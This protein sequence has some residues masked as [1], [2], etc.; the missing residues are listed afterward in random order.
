[1]RNNESE[2][3]G[4]MSFYKG[5]YQGKQYS[6]MYLQME[7]AEI[8]NDVYDI[9]I[10]AG[11]GGKDQGEIKGKYTEADITLK[12]CKSIKRKVRCNGI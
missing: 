12:I 8:P 1:M 6:L 2:E 9:V 4:S 10:D 7:D 3:K 5:K 11:H